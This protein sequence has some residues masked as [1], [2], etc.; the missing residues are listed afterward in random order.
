M[1]VGEDGWRVWR[2]VRLTALADTPAALGSAIEKE[3]VLHA[4]RRFLLLS[5]PQQAAGKTSASMVQPN[6]SA[7]FR[8]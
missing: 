7:Y 3:E 4:G 8:W 2:E 1:R 5:V 6:I